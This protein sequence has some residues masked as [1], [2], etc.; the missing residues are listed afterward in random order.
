VRNVALFN[1][2]APS[3]HFG[4][5]AVM[6]AIEDNVG[7]RGAR[8][9]HRHPVTRPWEADPAALAAI[10][11]ADLVLVNGEGTIHHGKPTAASLA[12][13]APYCAERNKPCFVINAT[14]QANGQEVMRDL[15]ASSG[16]WVRE[17]RSAE[18]AARW[19]INAD[20]CGDL[21]FAHAFPSQSGDQDRGLVLD[22]AHPDVTATMG[23]IAARLRA[24]FVAMRHNKKGMKSYRK[25]L[26]SRRFE[27]GKPTGIVPGIDTFQKF[28]AFLARRRFVVTGRFHGLCFALNSRV[29]FS[30]APLDVWKSEALLADLGL[31]P[32]RLLHDGEAPQPFSVREVELI[33]TYVGDIRGRIATMFDRILL[34]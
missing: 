26:L 14:I 7:S 28:A 27:S 31:H 13:L 34:H 3:R 18:E 9:I 4:C 21:S 10:E 24:D 5:E 29:P 30:A 23:V 15:A 12:R 2:T 20:V 17:G 1:D 19:G 8:L 22:A 25:G 6:A 32:G 16:L 33:S 11:G